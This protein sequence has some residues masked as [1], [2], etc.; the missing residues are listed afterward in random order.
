MNIIGKDF[1]EFFASYMGGTADNSSPRNSGELRPRSARI[2][3][4]NNRHG[5]SEQGC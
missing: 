3:L 5:Y 1:K 2:H 4:K